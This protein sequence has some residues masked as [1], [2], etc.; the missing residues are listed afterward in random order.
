MN[1]QGSVSPD[2][3]VLSSLEEEGLPDSQDSPDGAGGYGT[4]RNERD[5]WIPLTR[6]ETESGR[7]HQ[8]LGRTSE[9]TGARVEGARCQVNQGLRSPGGGHPCMRREGTYTIPLHTQECLGQK[10]VCCVYFNGS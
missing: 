7:G 3:V 6:V 2:R 10:N 8:G 5:E 9:G 4:E 1:K